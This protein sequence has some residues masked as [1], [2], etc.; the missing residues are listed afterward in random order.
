VMPRPRLLPFSAVT[1]EG[2]E[3]WAAWLRERRIAL[4]LQ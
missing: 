3:R 4:F 1:G 2:V